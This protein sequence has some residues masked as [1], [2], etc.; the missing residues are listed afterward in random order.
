MTEIEP[1]SANKQPCR[2]EDALAVLNRLR[3]AGHTAY[4]AGG[5]VRDEL[6]GI[7]PKD[8]DV[9]TDA[10]PQRVR[11]LFSNTQ[12]VGAAF[13]VILVRQGPSVVEVATFR[14]DDVY[15]DGRRPSKVHFTNAEED[16]KR[17]DFTINGLF[18]DPA[19]NE[20]IDYVGGRSDLKNRVLRAIGDPDARFAED[21]LRL[22]RAVRF[23][24]RFDLSID[25]A[26]ATAMQSQA[27]KLKAVSPERIAEELRLMLAP[28]SRNKAWKLLN[29]LGL[30]DVIFRFA[31]PATVNDGDA[32]RQIFVKLGEEPAPFGLALAAAALSR[33][34]D[35]EKLF[36]FENAR[37]VARAMR[38]A[39]RFSNEESDELSLTLSGI[40]MLLLQTPARLATKKRFLARDT[41]PLS[42]R[43]MIAMASAG[44]LADRLN[45]LELELKQLSE[46]EYAP[47][48]L[49]DGD[50]LVA[51]GLRPG[52]LFKRILQEVYDAQL[53][54]RVSSKEQAMKLAMEIAGST[55]PSS[56]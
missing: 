11:E 41:A 7:A 32:S 6:L 46:T 43:L 44:V 45:I 36:E 52:R 50:E 27:S 20:V 8:Y 33:E 28:A 12:A 51:A 16:A 24:S 30:M 56:G 17:R 23:A 29:E 4:F 54:S 22:L 39:L 47:A 53:E 55:G 5:C 10:G 31:P 48:P 19:K 13:G 42:R 40:G 37:A 25:P 18:L 34:G 21:H 2:R 9:A 14:S 15:L 35:I 26:T 49:L 38:Q 3:E 1:T